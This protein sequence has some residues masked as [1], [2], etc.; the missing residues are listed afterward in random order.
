L[1]ASVAARSPAV[2]I[3]VQPVV[4]H[5]EADVLVPFAALAGEYDAAGIE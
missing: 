5:A 2:V 1:F 3:F 4:L